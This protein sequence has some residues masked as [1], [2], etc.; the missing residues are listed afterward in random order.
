MGN[1]LAD[2]GRPVKVDM[3]DRVA[4]EVDGEHIIL[5][6]C[7]ESYRVAAKALGHSVASLAEGDAALGADHS[8]N[9]AGLVLDGR[10]CL[11]ERP[12]AGVVAA[13]RRLHAQALMRSDLI[14][15][16]AEAI[17]MG[18]GRG[19]IGPV[20]VAQQLGLEGAVE[21]FVLTQSLRVVG[22]AVQHY[23]VEMEEPDGEGSMGVLL[24]ISPGR[25]IVGQD[26][27]G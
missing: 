24:I 15:E 2:I 21:A 17:E 5:R 6:A 7:S 22:S 25:P 13:G 19:S 23:Y 20:G 3:I 8:D 16:G 12:V 18:L 11:W 4:A 10:E 1:T 14:V 26:G 9:I 27:V